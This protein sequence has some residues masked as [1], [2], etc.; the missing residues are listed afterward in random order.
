MTVPSERVLEAISIDAV[1]E[2]S[3]AASVPTLFAKSLAEP[4]LDGN[5][6]MSA[7]EMSVSSDIEQLEWPEGVEAITAWAVKPIPIAVRGHMRDSTHWLTLL[8]LQISAPSNSGRQVSGGQP[9]PGTEGQLTSSMPA[10][11]PSPVCYTSGLG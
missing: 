2:T 4:T 11:C 5:D 10:F 8:C 6:E 1:V 3:M 9:Q 7:V